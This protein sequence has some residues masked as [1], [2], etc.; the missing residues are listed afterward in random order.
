MILSTGSPLTSVIA[1]LVLLLLVTTG[2]AT[3]FTAGAVFTNP[4]VCGFD[5]TDTSPPPGDKRRGCKRIEEVLREE[6][7]LYEKKRGYTRRSDRRREEVIRG[8]VYETR[9]GYKR[10]EEVIRVFHPPPKLP[11]LPDR[12][13]RF[14]FIHNCRPVSGSFADKLPGVVIRGEVIRE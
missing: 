12:R 7:R 9:R 13:D 4:M 3:T 14:V 5:I 2:V 10:R 1:V 11:L 8:E 6:K